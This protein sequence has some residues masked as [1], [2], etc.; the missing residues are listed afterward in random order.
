MIELR[1][2]MIVESIEPAHNDIA[3]A[4]TLFIVLSFFFFSSFQYYGF[5][6]FTNS[7]CIIEQTSLYII[8]QNTKKQKPDSSN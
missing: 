1:L 7:K 3:L 8:N 6:A 5:Y 2:K 4:T